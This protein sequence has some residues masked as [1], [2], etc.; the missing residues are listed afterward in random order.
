[1]IWSNI[2]VG[3]NNCCFLVCPNTMLALRL[4][5]EHEAIRQFIHDMDPG[6]IAMFAGKLTDHIRFEER[7]LFPH[8][9]ETLSADQLNRIFSSLDHQ[10]GCAASWAEEF[11]K[12]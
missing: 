6:S 10:D 1:M 5:N 3:R 2:L 9:E 4:K 12:S 7:E 11:W 8:L